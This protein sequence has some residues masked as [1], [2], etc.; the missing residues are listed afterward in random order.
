MATSV[1]G[2]GAPRGYEWL[3]DAYDAQFDAARAA[4]SRTAAR[5][6]GGRE[7]RPP[8]AELPPSRGRVR[9]PLVGYPGA[10]GWQDQEDVNSIAPEDYRHCTQVF[11]NPQKHYVCATD[12]PLCRVLG[13]TAPQREYE[14][15]REERSVLHWGQ[16]KLMLS[17]IEFLTKMCSN[18]EEATVV[19]AGA[20][21]GTHISG[22]SAMFPGVKF[23]L[24]DP[25]PFTCKETDYIEVR[26]ELMTD[27]LAAQLAAEA[28]SRGRAVYFVSDVRSADYQQQTLEENEQN[29][30][31]DMELQK[32]WHSVLDPVSSMLKFRLPW[33]EGATE[34]LDGD[35][36]LPVWGP[37][38]TTEA[39][40][41]TPRHAVRGAPPELRTYDNKV[42]ESQMMEFNVGTRVG[43]YPHVCS[44]TGHVDGEGLC[45]CY[46]CASEVLV[47]SEYLKYAE[48][49]NFPGL[50]SSSQWGGSTRS[51]RDVNDAQSCQG[52]T[53]S[54]QV[55]QL[56]RT[57]S[58][59]CA[60]DRTLLHPAPDPDA[61][62]SVIDSRQRPN[63][64]TPRRNASATVDGGAGKRPWGHGR[65]QGGSPYA[66]GKGER[67]HTGKYLRR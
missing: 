42:Y 39:R 59:M 53:T 57:L 61:R 44:P 35:V 23:V 55:A 3:Y 60:S 58:L 19:Y 25:L 65:R 38:A 20:A 45:H 14:E 18:P 41:I 36:H 51:S 22:L 5:A 2:R 32:S 67:G 1:V 12:T 48:R 56:S 54:E 9:G 6:G 50:W 47:L 4:P 10:W 30:A 27:E 31:E 24:V 15:R 16:R 26:N 33:S 21:P 43:L 46:D 28:L 37:T 7:T 52:R 13:A 34:Y 62:K 17:E 11:A 49:W 64:R 40:L 66:R 29:I 8:A 63:G